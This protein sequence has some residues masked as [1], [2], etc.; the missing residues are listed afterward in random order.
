MRLK[1]YRDKYV[2][3]AFFGIFTEER[4]DPSDNPDWGKYK[5]KNI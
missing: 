1:R 2:Q 4:D 3:L 5:T